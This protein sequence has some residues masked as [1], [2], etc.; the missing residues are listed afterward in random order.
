MAKADIKASSKGIS[1]SADRGSG[2]EPKWERSPRKR[3]SAERS[4][5]TSPGARA[6]VSHFLDPS[7]KMGSSGEHYAGWI[8]EMGAQKQRLF[9]GKTPGRELLRFDERGSLVAQRQDLLP[10]NRLVE[11]LPSPLPQAAKPLRERAG[12][13]RVVRTPDPLPQRIERLLQVLGP[14]PNLQER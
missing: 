10:H 12:I 14:L 7:G 13:G 11:M 2:S 8:R 5:R 4:L 6:M 9:K 3:L 1:T